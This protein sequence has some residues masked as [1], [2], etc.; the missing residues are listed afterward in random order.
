MQLI[1]MIVVQNNRVAQ[2][3]KF[4]MDVLGEKICGD[5]EICW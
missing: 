5:L 3:H 4:V 1:R 2:R